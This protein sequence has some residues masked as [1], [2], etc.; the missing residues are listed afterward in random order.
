[1]FDGH[2]F[3]LFYIYIV[4]VVA[5]VVIVTSEEMII[6]LLLCLSIDLV[7]SLL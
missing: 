7:S 6:G 3:C 2:T 1:M 5:V 4:V